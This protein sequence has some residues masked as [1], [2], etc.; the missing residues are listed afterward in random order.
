MSRR[1]ANIRAI[2]ADH[3]ARE[4]LMVQVIIATQARESITTTE[5]Q[6]KAAYR[7]A[8]SLAR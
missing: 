1:R 2:L 5:E 8:R 3:E 6:A 4:R 7:K